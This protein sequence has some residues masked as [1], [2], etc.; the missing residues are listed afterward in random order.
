MTD[1]NFVEKTKIRLEEEEKELEEQLLEFAK[2]DKIMRGNWDTKYPNFHGSSLEEEADEVEEFENLKAIE[3]T[4]EVKLAGVKIA[5]EKIKTG[6]YG[7]CEKCQK[8]IV[9]E[10]LEALPETKIC[11][12]CKK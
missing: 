5:L 9:P 12:R 7:V 2:K 3:A 8:E 6:Q 4:L 10:R 1:K 11:D